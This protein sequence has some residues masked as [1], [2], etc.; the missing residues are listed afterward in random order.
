V[1]LHHSIYV[2]SPSDSSKNNGS[3][4]R[5]KAMAA[6][7]PV[8]TASLAWAVST[9]EV[10]LIL[11][12]EEIGEVMV[13]LLVASRF[14]DD[15]IDCDVVARRLDVGLDAADAL[16]TID[17]L[18]NTGAAVDDAPMKAGV[19]VV[20]TSS[21]DGRLQKHSGLTVLVF[22]AVSRVQGCATS[23][24]VAKSSLRGLP[25]PSRHPLVSS[26][27]GPRPLG[28]SPGQQTRFFSSRV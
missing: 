23:V 4:H 20:D 17:V 3:D 5:G 18:V 8:E 9:L 26:N 2:L 11:L 21:S 24:L 7:R 12:E 1:R 25:G 19:A 6:A 10:V 16:D 13:A 15:S 22:P 28:F 14:V 27:N